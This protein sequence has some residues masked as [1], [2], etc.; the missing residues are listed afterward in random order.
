MEQELQ[1]KIQQLKEERN[2]LIL[3][4]NYQID[5]VQA[6][7]DFVGDSFGLSQKAAG[8]DKDVI[9]FCGVSF[10]V[11]TAAILAPEKT[12]LLP[13]KLAGCPMADMITADALREAKEKYPEAAVVCYVNSSAEVKAESDICCTS[14]NAVNI[15]NSLAEEQ[16]LFVPDG[17]LAHWVS[18]NSSK[19][20]IPW[21]GFCP[22]HHKITLTD[23][24]Q[25]RKARP[26]APVA[27]HPECHPDLVAKADFV[28]STGGILDFA[29]K[30]DAE[31]IIIGT[32]MGILHRLKEENPD[33]KFYLL[34]SRL[35]CPNMK[36]TTLE[37]VAASLEKM[38]TVITVPEEVACK[39]RV[40]LE[41]MLAVG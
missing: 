4:H 13:E 37:K 34:S 17:N 38:Q 22:T 20:V 35:V 10:M 25:V 6:I 5:D 23:I 41:K 30:S 32:E 2:A 36:F 16:V 28:G 21:E 18:L 15:V 26:G 24:D 3:A 31:E 8:T 1:K 14:S 7:A 39:A 29:R 33:K 9:V 12:V 19:K 11:E 27:V 40:A